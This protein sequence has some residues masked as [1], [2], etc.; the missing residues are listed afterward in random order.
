MFTV[1]PVTPVLSIRIQNI[2]PAIVIPR[3]QDPGFVRPEDTHVYYT[4]YLVLYDGDYSANLYNT[5]GTEAEYYA[6]NYVIHA[7][8]Y[9]KYDIVSVKQKVVFLKHMVDSLFYVFFWLIVI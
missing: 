2:H 6:V 3:E 9:I 1:Y 7:V 4:L 8:Y 5:R